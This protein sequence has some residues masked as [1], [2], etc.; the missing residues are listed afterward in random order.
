MREIKV[1]CPE[2]RMYQLKLA[3]LK[4]FHM[5]Y[6]PERSPF[7]LSPELCFSLLYSV[8]VLSSPRQYKK[9]SLPSLPSHTPQKKTGEKNKKN[10]MYE[11]NVVAAG[12]NGHFLHVPISFILSCQ[13]GGRLQFYTRKWKVGRQKNRGRK[14]HKERGGWGGKKGTRK[15]KNVSRAEAGRK[16]PMGLS[17]WKLTSNCL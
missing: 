1:L 13:G 3:E 11:A 6:F 8:I 9:I 15:I 2:S 16:L 4:I 5:L 10:G 17:A 12:G 7:F 14:Y